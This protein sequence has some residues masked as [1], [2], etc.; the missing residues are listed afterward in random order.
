MPR[1]PL[2]LLAPATA[3][4]LAAGLA[5]P[6]AA[7]TYIAVSDEHL[8]SR[9]TVI[10]TFEVL[11]SDPAPTSRLMTEYHLR[12]ES[13]LKGDLSGATAVVRIP[14][15]EARGEG[16]RLHGMPSFQPGE[17]V[18]LFLAPRR[19]GTWGIVH[20][21]LGAFHT[22]DRPEGALL[23]R[24]HL[25]EARGLDRRGRPATDDGT[26]ARDRARFLAWVS[27]RAAGRARTPDYLVPV[28]VR[29]LA[30]RFTVF[31]HP[32]SGNALRW[33]DFDFGE[34]VVWRADQNGAP[35]V[36]DGGVSAV[37]AGL[38]A[39]NA[40]TQTNIRLVWGGT[41]PPD[42]GFDDADGQNMVL[43]EDPHGEIDEPFDCF[44]GGVV[45]IGG[46]FYVT[47]VLSYRNQ[48]WHPIVE[49]VVILN[50]NL[51]C[52]LR[53]N[54]VRLAEIVGHELGHTLGFGHSCGDTRSPSCA[55]NPALDDALMRATVHNDGRGARL[56]ADDIAA[57]RGSYGTGGGS[58]PR[59]P[60][61]L[62]FELHGND[63]H[64][65]WNDR[66]NNEQGFTVY[67]RIG[68][69]GAFTAIGQTGSG[70]TSFVD[71]DLATGTYA[72][73]VRSFNA[74]G[75]SGSS[76]RV[77]VMIEVFEPGMARFAESAFYGSEESDF[78]QVTLERIGGRSG[79]LSA[80]LF[81]RDLSATA[82]FDYGARDLVVTWA[83]GDDAPK[84]VTITIVDDFTEED[85]E[86]IELLLETVAPPGGIGVPLG[87]A[88]V[89]IADNDGPPGCVPSE[90]RLCLLDNRFKVEVEWRNQRNGARGPGR[91]LPGSDVS[92][93]FW[94][95]QQEN[96]ELIVKMLDGR[97]LTGAH[98]LF[99]GALSDVEY[100]VTVTDTATGARKLYR[101]AP[102]NI[103][104]V[105][106]TGAFPQSAPASGAAAS[107]EPRLQALAWLG[108]A[109]PAP[110]RSPL[111]AAPAT[112]AP[113][114]TCVPDEHALCLLGNRFR[115]EVD[116]RNHRNGDTGVGTAVPNS[117]Q[118]GMFWF[119]DPANVELVV[120]S[121]DGQ[122]VNGDFWFFYGALSDVEYTITVTDT[123]T[124]AEQQYQ[125]AGGNICG[126]GDIA[127][128]PGD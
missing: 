112:L 54:S 90:R 103:C 47:Q 45:A 36:A 64:L 89:A 14:G 1:S 115:V 72:Y 93:Y 4:L 18:L 120:K 109:V 94:F 24:P 69:S 91:A 43:Y 110:R 113:R 13:L 48:S 95:F 57:A 127:A 5:V 50:R 52:F 59:A 79:E 68:G 51:S 63:V 118:T 78:A 62:S 26:T 123:H 9:A 71:A 34:P 102:G 70:Q 29:A 119:F 10:G 21:I 86:L 76:N 55:G 20:A 100:W 6:A 22:L 46:P 25:L 128:F 126:V 124:G 66:S 96:I 105:G 44:E 39:W 40:V 75:E 106:D 98:W 104:G 53:G 74:S 56:A 65:A 33:F 114:Q 15:G 41:G 31:R 84:I 97:P 82:P 30:P 3:A 73:E 7:T 2:A 32:P 92:G 88:V 122:L 37:Q 85:T 8:I 111:A 101:N 125:N 11:A 77:T 87:S 107:P 80:R 81:T 17:S 116:W 117:D 16:L 38:A 49:G 12:V 121:L 28:D 61:R 58:A 35:G 60:N 23:V 27:D 108:D 83:A 19:D 99:Y 67:R 42:P